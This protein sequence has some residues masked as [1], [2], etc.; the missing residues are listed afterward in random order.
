MPGI[1]VIPDIHGQADKLD[2]L[3]A[4]LGWAKTGAG[5]RAPEPGRR[6]RF[7]GDFIDRGLENRRVLHRVRDLIDHGHAAAV[8][9]NHELNALHFHWQDPQTGAPLRPRSLKTIR[10][11][12]SFLDEF[13][14]H[15]AETAEWLDFIA[16]L[17]LWTDEG[18]L[19]AVH[20]C[21]DAE[22]IA[23]LCALAPDGRLSRD[24]LLEAGREGTALNRDV[25]TLTKGP[26]TPLPPPHHFHDKDGHARHA[27]RLA[28]WRAGARRWR[29][30]AISVPDPDALPDAPLPEDLSGAIY[31]AG[32]KPVIF[33]HYWMRAPL[34]LEAPNALCLDASAGTDGPLLAYRWE[35]GDAALSLSRIT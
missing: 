13:P 17:P 31:P 9:G 2:G 12:R 24:L 28:W 19:R 6:I 25:E 11:H 20:A 1:D 4:R 15:G 21:W 8:M 16:T 32:E 10:Q 22:A 14:L 33:G 27:M 5:W 29:E 34:A 26:E 30:A 18:P 3:L 23:R 7:L 35:E